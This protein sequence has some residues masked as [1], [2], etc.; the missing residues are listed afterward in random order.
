[1]FANTASKPSGSSVKERV[2][3]PWYRQFWPWFLIALPAT[4][5]VAGFFTLYL[6]IKYSDTLVSDN[7]YKD[8]LAINQQLSQDLRAS[9][10]ALTARLVF[11][12][13]RDSDSD[14]VVLHL[15]SARKDVVLPDA[16]SLQLLHPTDSTADRVLLFV[17]ASDG[18]YRARLPELPAHRFYL[19]LL[20]GHIIDKEKQKLAEWRLSTEINFDTEQTVIFSAAV[21]DKSTE[22]NDDASSL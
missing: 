22:V 3:P 16:L 14:H 13:D 20:P 19:R 11:E 6:A 17:A 10:L 9:E 8:G 2:T 15:S 7:Y 4:V 5:V 18:R 1:M 21:F 12:N